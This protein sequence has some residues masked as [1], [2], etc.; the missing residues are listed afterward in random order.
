MKTLYRISILF[1]CIG[2]AFVLIKGSE[3]LTREWIG[4]DSNSAVEQKVQSQ[5]AR[6]AFGNGTARNVENEAAASSAGNGGQE[7]QNVD[8]TAAPQQQ[9]LQTVNSSIGGITT[10]DTIYH[11]LVCDLTQGTEKEV[12]EE[13][14]GSYMGKNRQQLMDLLDI[15]NESPPL[16]EQSR[17][18]QSMELVSFS[19]EDITVRKTYETALYY[20]CVVVED[21]YLT[22]YDEK[23]KNVILYTDIRLDALPEQ[24]KQEIIDGKYFKTE[25]DL[26][27]FLESYSS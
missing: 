8:S 26:Y 19:E 20:C 1:N 15:Y 14:P 24:L 2:M 13:I 21:D 7:A 16:D 27:H 5:T 18:F 17:G 22:V 12:I 23:R 25:Q 10:C 4:A 6:N 11:I 9:E 3:L